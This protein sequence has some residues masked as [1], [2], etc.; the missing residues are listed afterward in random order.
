MANPKI[1]RQ[2]VLDC[3][4]NDDERFEA[5]YYHVNNLVYNN[6]NNCAPMHTKLN[7]YPTNT[8]FSIQILVECINL[9]LKEGLVELI[10]DDKSNNGV[11]VIH[12]ETLD[13]DDFNRF[14]KYWLR[15]KK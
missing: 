14:L 5:V 2:D 6:D 4:S 11:S 10:T 3:L 15:L 8:E 1:L 9:L 12:L 7:Q 13:L